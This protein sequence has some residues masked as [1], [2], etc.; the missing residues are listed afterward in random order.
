MRSSILILL[1]TFGV[2]EAMDLVSVQFTNAPNQ[3]YYMKQ[4]CN[5][6]PA[7]TCCVP[8][9]IYVGGLGWG[10]FHAKHIM[11]ENLPSYNVHVTAWR[12]QP[13]RANCDGELV[14]DY[15][16]IGDATAHYTNHNP[17]GFSGGRYYP[18]VGRNGNSTAVNNDTLAFP[19]VG[20]CYPDTIIYRGETYLDRGT[21]DMVYVSSTGDH[22]RGSLLFGKS[23]DIQVSNCTLT[24]TNP[25]Q[26]P[27]MA[28]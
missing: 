4:S 5:F 14:V 10:W 27:P 22:L 9:D 16:T 23:A 25:S 12:P 8:I 26:Q 24:R 28:P 7:H 21:D 17:A 15:L 18:Q 1:A 19:P 6:L 3:P 2:I 11:F 20:V 13:P